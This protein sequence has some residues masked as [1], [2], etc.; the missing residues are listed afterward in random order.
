MSMPAG[1]GYKTNPD[2]NWAIVAMV[3][4][5]RVGAPITP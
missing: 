4:N 2:D 5:H 1:Y 3:M